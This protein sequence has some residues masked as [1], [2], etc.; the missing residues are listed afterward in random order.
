MLIIL[1]VSAE[2]LQPVYH[3]Q[4]HH[5]VG[6]LLQAR[7][8]RQVDIVGKNTLNAVVDMILH[9]P[10]GVGTTRIPQTCNAE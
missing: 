3:Y 6:M 5:P 1:T 10:A 4:L 7:K 9:D 8:H 2:L